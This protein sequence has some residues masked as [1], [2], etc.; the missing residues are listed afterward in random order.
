MKRGLCFRKRGLI[1]YRM[2]F[3]IFS[4][5]CSLRPTPHF[6][7]LRVLTIYQK[8][9]IFFQ[10]SHIFYEKR[11]NLLES[12]FELDMLIVT[13]KRAICFMK[14]GLIHW[15]VGFELDMLIETQLFSFSVLVCVY[16]LIK[17]QSAIKRALHSIKRA[18]SSIKG[19]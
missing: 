18:Q 10:N 16:C 3:Q 17:A 15:S 8:S 4:W 11:P 13:M 6:F 2:N 1:Q 19:A 7:F 5:I 12:R 14:R 9:P